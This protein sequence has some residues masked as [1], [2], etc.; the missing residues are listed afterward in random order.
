MRRFWT[1]AI[2]LAVVEEIDTM[3]A[4]DRDFWHCMFKGSIR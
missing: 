2:I 4:A 1:K 3:D